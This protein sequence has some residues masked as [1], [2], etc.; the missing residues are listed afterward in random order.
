MK[1]CGSGKGFID[2][3]EGAS[4]GL[5]DTDKRTF[6]KDDIEHLFGTADFLPEEVSFFH[7][8]GV[9][10]SGI[11][12]FQSLGDNQASF[13]GAMKGREDHILVNIG[14]S[15]QIC[16]LTDS[17]PENLKGIEVRPYPGKNLVVGATLTGGKA[18]ALLIDFFYDI[19]SL[20]GYSM[21]KEEMMEILNRMDIAEPV[22]PLSVVSSFN[23]TRIDPEQRGMIS[24]IDLS[25]FD[26]RNLVYG[27][28]EAMVDELKN[29]FDMNGLDKL[30]SVNGIV[31]S[32]NAVRRNPLL[33]RLIEKKFNRILFL[34]DNMEE[35]ACGAAYYAYQGTVKEA[36]SDNE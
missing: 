33:Q 9:D 24:G 2:P 28:V 4:F 15:G 10:S 25:N 20:F 12:V 19:L 6:Y 29:L 1:L 13:L 36:G 8:C 17:H 26:S 3:S 14:T 32:G 30:A 21:D 7:K 35:A 18:Y 27:F 31:G 22:N 34:S 16:F 5:Y 23:G 11:P